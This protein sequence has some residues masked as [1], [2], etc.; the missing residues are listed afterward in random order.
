MF[1]PLKNPFK[2]TKLKAFLFFFVLATVFWVLTKFSRQYTATTT[3]G[4]KYVAV[5]EATLVS[6]DNLKEISFDLT[7]NGFEFLF[8]NLK[9]PTV[10]IDVSKYYTEADTAVVIPKTELIRLI[11]KYLNANAA[12]KNPSVEALTVSLDTIVTKKVPVI[13]KTDFSYKDGF[14]P[15]DYMIV[16]PD[17]VLI[18][19]P[20]KAL[21]EIQLAT[22]TMVSVKNVDKS[23][24]VSAAIENTKNGISIEPQEVSISLQVAEFSQKEMNLHITVINVPEET[25]IKLIPNVVS[26][27]FDVSVEDFRVITEKDFKLVCDY[28][29][30]NTEENFMIPRIT[31]SPKGVTNIEFE[32]KKIDF[33]I[34]K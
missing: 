6:S 27:S 21:E 26:V 9:S 19:G 29:E 1:K 32:T 14:K 25:V 33:L 30:R 12:V 5:P 3:A 23:M 10:E 24:V 8:F 7:A 13:P 22:T 17:S 31:E 15:I 4:I 28:S 18:S 11:S 16:S 20:S 2:N 34:F